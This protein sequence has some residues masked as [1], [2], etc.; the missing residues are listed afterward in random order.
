MV[1]DQWSMINGPRSK[2]ND[3]CSMVN[4]MINPTL[5]WFLESMTTPES[6]VISFPSP[7]VAGSVYCWNTRQLVVNQPIGKGSPS[8]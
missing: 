2:V 6:G 5:E 1:N 4:V 7:P 3:Q 8:L